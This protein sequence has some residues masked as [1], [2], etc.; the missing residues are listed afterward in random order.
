MYQPESYGIALLL[1]LTSMVCWGSWAN[2]MK[3]TPGWRFQLFYW[4]YVLGVLLM[5][6]FWGITLG[7]MGGSPLSFWNNLGQA[8]NRHIIY[9]LLA[10]AVF[11]VANLL[12]VAAIEIAGLAVAFPIGIGVALVEGVVTSYILAPRGQPVLLFGGLLLVVVA[13]GLD[14]MAY[15]RKEAESSK[16]SSKGIGISIASGILMGLFYPLVTKA[17][18]GH[19]ALGPYAVGFIF[20]V[21][22]LVCTIPV[23]ALLMWHPL[24]GGEPVSIKG[25]FSVRGSWHL[26]AVAGGLVWCTGTIMNFVSAHARVIGPAVSYAIGNGATMV[27]AFWGVVVWREFT[28]APV[29]TGKLL[30]LMF[31][32]FLLGLGAIAI[33]PVVHF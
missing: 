18:T 7:S 20:A 23:N 6:L 5:S 1:M 17:I 9:G 25:Y 27:S 24:T 29:G 10:G 32:F 2:T 15:R 28:Q 33:A 30:A 3:L 8:D 21:G 19:N 16:V 22:I 13:I 14:A 4:D 12:L 11:N 31:A 26:L